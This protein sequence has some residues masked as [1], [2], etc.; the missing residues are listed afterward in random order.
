MS[1]PAQRVQT[2]KMAAA[3]AHLECQ[4]QMLKGTPRALPEAAPLGCAFSHTDYLSDAHFHMHWLVKE[5][6]PPQT[7]RS[8]D[9]ES[10][11]QTFSTREPSA[12]PLGT[13]V[14]S[15]LLEP[16]RRLPST[17]ATNPAVWLALGAHPNMAGKWN[18]GER[19]KAIQ[20]SNVSWKTL[21]GLSPLARLVSTSRSRSATALLR[22]DRYRFCRSSS[23]PS[24]NIKHCGPTP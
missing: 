13:A 16:S 18:A 23:P 8:V 14:D 20:E 24:K 22:V 3:K 4:R 15:C 6:L 19:A 9:L 11:R 17:R 2:A 10:V 12:I 1:A 21:A 5:H 7:N